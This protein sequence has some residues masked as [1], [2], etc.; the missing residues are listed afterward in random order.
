MCFR[1]FLMLDRRPRG[2]NPVGLLGERFDV[3]QPLTGLARGVDYSESVVLKFA[4]VDD[5]GIGGRCRSQQ[6]MQP[7]DGD[8][9]DLLSRDRAQGPLKHRRAAQ[10]SMRRRTHPRKLLQVPF[11][12]RGS[13][14]IWCGSAGHQ[15]AQS[16]GQRYLRV[17]V[18][19]SG[20]GFSFVAADHPARPGLGKRTTRGRGIKADPFVGI[21]GRALL[22]QP[23]CRVGLGRPR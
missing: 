21:R 22:A 11:G 3:W 2:G 10:N 9:P 23:F 4:T 8:A 18:H 13:D 20:G 5:Q 6:V 16:S 17:A 15:K 12:V 1:L 14:D 19:P 7:L